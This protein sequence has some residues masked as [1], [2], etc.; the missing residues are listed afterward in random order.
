ML[1]EMVHLIVTIF[2]AQVVVFGKNTYNISNLPVRGYETAV[3]VLAPG[4]NAEGNFFLK[5][6][7]WTDFAKKNNLGMIA[8]SYKSLVD[9]TDSG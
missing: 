4:I 9:E 6:Q 3:L 7:C 5:E 8:L 1:K 2:L